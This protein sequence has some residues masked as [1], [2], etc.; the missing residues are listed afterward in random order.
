VPSGIRPAWRSRYTVLNRQWS[1]I[2]RRVDALVAPGKNETR[3]VKQAREKI[4]K[5]LNSELF[6]DDLFKGTLSKDGEISSI[7]YN[8]KRIGRLSRDRAIGLLMSYTATLG[9][10]AYDR[11]FGET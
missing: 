7:T 11:D 6:N 8:C 1:K 2:I 5:K 10:P 3:E 4:G 9:R